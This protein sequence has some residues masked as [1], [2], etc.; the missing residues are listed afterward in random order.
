M[1][2]VR[3]PTWLF[4]L[5]L[6][7][8]GCSGDKEP[9]PAGQGKAISGAEKTEN[10]DAKIET[11]MAKLNPDDRALAEAQRFCAINTHERLGSMGTPVKVMVKEH[12]VFL[13]C[14]G[15]QKKALADPDK[16]LASVE[17][18]KATARAESAPK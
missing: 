1:R 4:A 2:N 12:A 18:L 11:E 17:E 6:L 13:C 3:N 16:T 14:K 8:A 7:L 5:A 10:E 9:K 15:C